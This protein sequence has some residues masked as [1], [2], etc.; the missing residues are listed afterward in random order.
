MNS[1]VLA[2][3]CSALVG[4][5]LGSLSFAIIVSRIYAHD[6][7]RNYGSHNAGMTNVLRVYGL[8][9][10]AATLLGDFGKGILAVFLGRLIFE[11]L[12]VSGMDAGYI[13]GL[14]ALL[15]H[16]FPLW[17]G[18]RGGKGVLT[19]IGIMMAVNPLVMGMILLLL[20]PFVL[21]VRIVS[22]AS[23]IGAALYPILTYAMLVFQNKDPLWDTV[24]AVIFAALVIW[25]HR[26][27]I[28]RLMNGTEKRL[29]LPKKEKK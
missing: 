21:V 3:L 14:A 13:A 25:M 19:S 22:L 16:L 1:T 7:V 28:K 10:A 17:F 6:D 9:P 29:T 27:N 20:I 24:F 8:G 2:V 4:Y 23:I 5:L 18:F 15:G 12:G 26:S 11:T